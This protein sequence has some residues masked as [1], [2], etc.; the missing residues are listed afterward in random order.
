[1][2]SARVCAPADP[3]SSEYSNGWTVPPSVPGVINCT[4]PVASLLPS[5]LSLTSSWALPWSTMTTPSRLKSVTA[6]GSMT[7]Y[8][9]AHDLIVNQRINGY[10]QLMKS[11]GRNSF[12]PIWKMRFLEPSDIDL[13]L[14]GRLLT[15]EDDA[16][17]DYYAIPTPEVGCCTWT[18][19]LKNGAMD[20]Y[21]F[22]NLHRLAA[23]L[24]SGNL[25]ASSYN[26]TPKLPGGNY[27]PKGPRWC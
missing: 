20:V 22:T 15:E 11:C 8:G 17:I 19:H 23:H 5:S 2:G 3:S 9:I 6:G 10:F 18:M 25:L 13:Y 14:F 7:F 12:S 24:V 4:R 27:L 16:P 21:R 26:G 1:M